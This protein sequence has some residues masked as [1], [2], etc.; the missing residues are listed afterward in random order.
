MDGPWSLFGARLHSNREQLEEVFVNLIQSVTRGIK[1]IRSVLCS[2]RISALLAEGRHRQPKSLVPF[3]FKAYSQSDEDGIIQEIFRRIG[4]TNRSFIEFG[5][6]DGLE[7]NTVYLLML[8]WTGLWMDGNAK[9]IRSIL[10]QH[11]PF[12]DRKS[13]RVHSAMVTCENI[14]GL[15]EGVPAEPDLLSIDIDN[16]DY[17]LWS[18]IGMIR[19]RVVVI[20]Y[21][22]T[23]RPPAAVVVPYSSHKGWPGGSY[24]GASLS[25]LELL[26]R[27]KGYSLVGCNLV[28][29]NAFFVRDDLVGD[30]FLSPYTAEMHYEPPEY[31]LF[32]FLTGSH[33]RAI[34]VYEQV[35][36]KNS[37]S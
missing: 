13:L 2:Q 31:Y 33:P 5:C 32:Q 10:H 7:N 30:K 23:I 9:K 18:A 34:G 37:S 3:G 1:S 6:G 27:K 21:N 16:N 20:E 35:G 12:I 15:L 26:G 14:E 4:V 28:G 11:K 36:E 24:Y 17:W 22:A 8:G 25:A 29:T 19:P